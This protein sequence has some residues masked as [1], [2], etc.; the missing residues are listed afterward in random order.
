MQ[1][2]QP[3]RQATPLLRLVL[4][5]HPGRR[6]TRV[7]QAS[8]LGLPRAWPAVSQAA[9]MSASAGRGQPC[10]VSQPPAA[11]LPLPPV[12]PQRDGCLLVLCTDA[13]GN[14]RTVRCVS[15]SRV[16]PACA[17]LLHPGVPASGSWQSFS[18][19]LCMCLLPI[20]FGQWG[21]GGA[22]TDARHQ[23]PHTVEAFRRHPPPPLYP[24]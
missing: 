6:D 19:R 5:L 20:G 22:C 17:G 23:G 8:P 7:A 13:I 4:A 18:P 10:H 24:A 14:G 21:G 16:S 3:G 15:A 9:G 1:E 12:L 2:R 11:S